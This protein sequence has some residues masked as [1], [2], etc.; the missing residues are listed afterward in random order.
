LKFQTVL[1]LVACQAY[2]LEGVNY[3]YEYSKCPNMED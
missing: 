1:A 3:G 2:A